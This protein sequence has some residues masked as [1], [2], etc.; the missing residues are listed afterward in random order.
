[1]LHR[2]LGAGFCRRVFVLSAAVCAVCY[3]SVRFA[4]TEA[5]AQSAPSGTR[6]L[7]TPT[8][9]STQIAFAYAQNI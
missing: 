2:I 3:L 7:R 6:L 4:G 1:M 8:V 9:S 5:Q